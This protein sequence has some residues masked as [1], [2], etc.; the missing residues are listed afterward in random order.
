MKLKY[1][2]QY[3]LQH[4]GRIESIIAVTATRESGN[5]VTE[6]TRYFISS[7]SVNSPA[8]H[9][10]CSSLSLGYRNQFTLGA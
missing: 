8:K 6:E 2:I 5:K 3:L 4:V 7:L 9:G 10:A 1:T